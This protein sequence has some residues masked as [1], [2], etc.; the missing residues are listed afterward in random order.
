MFFV[1]SGRSEP[2][3]LQHLQQRRAGHRRQVRGARDDGPRQ[4]PEVRRER[5]PHERPGLGRVRLDVEVAAALDH[6]DRERRRPGRPALEIRG[7]AR[8][9]VGAAVPPASSCAS[10]PSSS[11]AAASAFTCLT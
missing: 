1:A 9:V 2:S 4:V 6:R 3:L 7:V 5:P 10:T 11:T 8:R